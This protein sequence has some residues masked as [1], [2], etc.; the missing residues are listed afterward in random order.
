MNFTSS[1]FNRAFTLTELLIVIAIIAVLIAILLPALQKARMAAQSAACLSNLRQLATASVMY[2]NDNSGYVPAWGFSNTITGNAGDPSNGWVSGDS[3][4]YVTLSK[5]VGAS[6]FVWNSLSTA[7]STKYQLMVPCYFCPAATPV[8][9]SSSWYTQY[10]FNYT[11]NVLCS[12]PLPY[13]NGQHLNKYTWLKV[14]RTSAS[15]F[16]VFSDC[17]NATFTGFPWYGGANIGGDASYQMLSFRH[18]P[19]GTTNALINAAFLDGHAEPLTSQDYLF[20]S[21][22][23]TN[24]AR[25]GFYRSP[26]PTQ[27]PLGTTN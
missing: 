12:C 21:P 27:F 7:Q 22:D 4:W 16:V 11:I 2:S 18:G 17:A 1:R 13:G 19:V 9:P 24:L 14:T 6:Q 20:A 15:T 10:P 23:S 26:T 8:D 5:Y 3:Y 25:F